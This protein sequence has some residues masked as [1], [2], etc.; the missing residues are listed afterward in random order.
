[1]L[2]FFSELGLFFVQSLCTKHRHRARDR[3]MKEV[4]KNDQNEI[5]I[6]MIQ[7]THSF[8]VNSSEFPIAVNRS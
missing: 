6:H 7:V 8:F 2:I 5:S 3:K 4:N 1:M